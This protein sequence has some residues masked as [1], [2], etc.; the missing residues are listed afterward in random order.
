LPQFVQRFETGDTRR[1]LLTTNSTATYTSKYDVLY[2]N[3]KFMR[4]AEMYLTRAEANFRAGTTVGA[5]PLADIN[6]IRTRARLPVLTAL[7]LPVI[8][9]ERRL[10]LAFEGFRLGDL[11]RNQESAFDPLANT[12][13]AWNSPKLVFPIPLREINANPNLTQNAGY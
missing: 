2:G 11:K 13:F 6:A 7:T 9:K 3:I 8:L 5:T 10:E 4:L 1:N 12:T